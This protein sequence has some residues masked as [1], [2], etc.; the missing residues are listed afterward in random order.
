MGRR[1][2]VRARD[3][4]VLEFDHHM[5]QGHAYILSLFLI[6]SGELVGLII[7]CLSFFFFLLIAVDPLEVLQT[8]GP[9]RWRRS[10]RKHDQMHVQ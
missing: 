3:H 7:S 5:A 10:A 8:L 1:Y 2:A 6:C 4:W 9:P